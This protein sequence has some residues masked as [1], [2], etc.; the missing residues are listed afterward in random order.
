MDRWCAEE[1]PQG[2]VSRV[3]LGGSCQ[4]S[5]ER[6]FDSMLK[7]STSD[8]RHPKNNLFFL[9]M[10]LTFAKIIPRGPRVRAARAIIRSV[11]TQM[12]DVEGSTL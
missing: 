11:R 10:W 6:H 9:T 1:H 12:A 8:L 7:G 5:P 4:A 2:A 3:G